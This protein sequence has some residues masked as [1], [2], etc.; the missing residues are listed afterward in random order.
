MKRLIWRRGWMK[1]K[2]G[3]MLLRVDPTQTIE[4]GGGSLNPHCGNDGRETW[5]AP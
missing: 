4:I 1:C 5:Y 2:L 3:S